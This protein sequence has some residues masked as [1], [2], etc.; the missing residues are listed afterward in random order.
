MYIYKKDEI[1]WL[2]SMHGSEVK[3]YEVLVKNPEGR[4]LEDCS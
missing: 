1:G 2:C 3:C 4:S